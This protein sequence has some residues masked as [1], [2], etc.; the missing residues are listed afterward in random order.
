MYYC[1]YYLITEKFVKKK[2]EKIPFP[3]LGSRI[4]NGNDDDDE[5]IKR[6]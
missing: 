1:C 2:K 6:F 4:A 5:N 3:V